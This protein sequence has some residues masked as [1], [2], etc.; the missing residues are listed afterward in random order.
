MKTHT[1]PTRRRVFM[2][3]YMT[4]GTALAWKEAWVTEKLVITKPDFGTL[5]AFTKELRGAFSA[6]DTEGDARAKLRQLRQGKNSVDEYV[7]K[8]RILAGK[9]KMQDD[10][11]LMEYFME[12][13]NTGILQN[14]FAN[15]TL[16]TTIQEWYEKASKHDAQ[17][18]RVKEILE[19]RRGPSYNTSNTN[20]TKK[21]FVPRY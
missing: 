14:I 21:T 20:Q 6:A 18:R 9:E 8:F 1:T 17:Y 2:L 15:E 12:G 13:I 10:K 11:A 16:P 5:E 3:S 4:K 7:A 19:R